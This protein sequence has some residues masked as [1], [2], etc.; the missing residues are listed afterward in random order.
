M[1]HLEVEQSPKKIKA[2]LFLVASAA[3]RNCLVHKLLGLHHF[4]KLDLLIDE[5]ASH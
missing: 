3:V 1:I 5:I 2:R 4:V